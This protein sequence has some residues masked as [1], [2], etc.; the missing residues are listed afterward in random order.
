MIKQYASYFVSYLLTNLK[1]EENISQIILFGSVA[2]GESTKQSD[3]DI[4]VELKKKNKKQ[5][6][7]IESILEEFYKSREA[8]IFK[9]KGIDN[10]ISLII[11]NL[12]D[13]RDLKSSIEST[14][15]VFYGPYISAKKED[16]GR[17]FLIIFWNKIGKNRGAFLNKLY[18][19]K[20][21]DKEYMGVVEKL[22]GRKIGK[23]S[24]VLPIENSKEV[25]DLLIKYKVDAKSIE[26][27]SGKL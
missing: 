19:V 5:E 6:K 25:L 8:L 21:R 14:G 18:G 16:T 20:I 22:G 17:K 1:K 9:S 15:I 23:S 24:I 3:V 26:I 10:K 11:G 2:K 7:E 4:L 12:E 13:F 27:S